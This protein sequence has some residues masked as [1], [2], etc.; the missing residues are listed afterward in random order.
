MSTELIIP[1]SHLELAVRAVK[2]ATEEKFT[3]RMDESLVAGLGELMDKTDEYWYRAKPSWSD[4]DIEEKDQQRAELVSG[5]EEFF[6]PLP[7]GPRGSF[8][9]RKIEVLMNLRVFLIDNLE[10][11]PYEDVPYGQAIRRGRY[12]P[13]AVT[14]SSDE[15]YDVLPYVVSSAMVDL[16]MDELSRSIDTVSRPS[17]GSGFPKDHA[18]LVGVLNYWRIARWLLGRP[19]R[20]PT[21]SGVSYNLERHDR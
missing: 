2:R 12:Y 8:S 19:S 9:L 18:E 11:P 5:L 16:V 4:E 13:D 6:R 7:T 3:E 17:G 21:F 20:R 15:T 10:R 14:L 1:V